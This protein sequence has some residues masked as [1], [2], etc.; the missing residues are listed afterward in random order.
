RELGLTELEQ[1]A[2]LVKADLLRRR[3]NVAEAGRIAQ[4]VHRWATDNCSVRTLARS[5]FV[6]SAVFQ[7][8]GDVSVALEH[9]VRSVDLLDDT[10]PASIRIDHLTRLAD[11]LA[12][13]GDDAARERYAEVHLL[14]GEL[15][16]VDRLLM[17][18]NNRAYS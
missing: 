16:D 4:D 12:L 6:L 18:L 11:C 8:L 9:A 7:E 2:Q 10:T 3:G 5:H 13:L 15:G 17:V 14:A 1:R